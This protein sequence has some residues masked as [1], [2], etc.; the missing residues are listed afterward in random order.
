MKKLVLFSFLMCSLLGNISSN[1]FSLFVFNNDE[2][3]DINDVPTYGQNVHIDVNHRSS[4]YKVYFFASPYY[5][6]GSDLYDGGE[7]ITDPLLIANHVNNPYNSSEEYCIRFDNQYAGV[8]YEYGNAVYNGQYAWNEHY[9]HLSV[10]SLSGGKLSFDDDNSVEK[11]KRYP[12]R[13]WTGY[14]LE[15]ADLNII[16]TSTY[17]LLEV[18]NNIPFSQLSKLIA[19]SVYKDKFGFGPEFIG[20]TYDKAL[21]SSR[22]RYSDYDRYERLTNGSLVGQGGGDISG[23]PYLIGNYGLQAVSHEEV[24]TPSS[25]L[26]YID[27][28]SSTS[29][30][31]IDGSKKD[32]NIIYLYPVF[33]AKNA[34]RPFEINGQFSS[35][36]KFRVNPLGDYT[37]KQINEIDYSNNRYTVPLQQ[38][39]NT[40]AGEIN[41]FSNNVY[42]NSSLNIQLDVDPL[43]NSSWSG[44]WITLLDS[45]FF[46][47]LDDGFYGIDIYYTHA[48]DQVDIDAAPSNVSNAV[49]A[50]NASNKYI[51]VIGSKDDDG[52]YGVKTYNY[53]Y[54]LVYVIGIRKMYEYRL[55]GQQVN[56][57]LD[58]YSSAEN[59]IIFKHTFTNLSSSFYYTKDTYIEGD[60][61]IAM[62]YDDR[63]NSSSVSFSF[64]PMSSA[65]VSQVNAEIALGNG[66]NNNR[67]EVYAITEETPISIKDGS[68]TKQLYVKETNRYELI[69]Y[70]TLEDGLPKSVEV[71]YRLAKASYSLII[72]SSKPADVKSFYGDLEEIKALN[73]FMGIATFETYT[74]I[75][76]NTSLKD[77]NGNNTYISIII[78]QF[79]GEFI[80]LASGVKIDYSLFVN[81]EYLLH[82]D[83]I[84]YLD[85]GR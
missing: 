59:S 41:Y 79:F 77:K 55:T 29:D 69:F 5:A 1:A 51:Q 71:A 18:E 4:V 10:E 58:D 53:L 17:A 34:G 27:G 36:M 35:F 45:T 8:A 82:R 52:N 83:T 42:I 15:N 68:N 49:D 85:N 25:S 73:T 48:Y 31:G 19:Q 61:T 50:F 62:L 16:E 28:L 7:E 30:L 2:I 6:T 26:A 65:H 22:A 11:I 40:N 46:K 78:H 76:E 66:V 70:V 33:A 80:D 64:T 12:K 63:V 47:S 54:S 38:S 3:I 57:S 9:Y 74:L 39:S 23:T 37:H 44:T 43:I 24:I 84:L 81:G 75:D 20:W 14:I 67:N 21:A 72:L 32:D 56:G 60:E 13:K